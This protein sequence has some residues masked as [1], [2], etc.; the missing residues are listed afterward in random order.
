[1]PGV[2]VDACE[3]LE[4]VVSEV[5]KMTARTTPEFENSCV[6]REVSAEDIAN[7]RACLIGPVMCVVR[8]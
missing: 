6:T 1:M 2:D 3:V 7:H 4:A 5:F 8:R